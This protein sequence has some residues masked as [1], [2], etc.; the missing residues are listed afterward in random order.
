LPLYLEVFN[1]PLLMEVG[2]F[3][4]L[5]IPKIRGH[6]DLHIHRWDFCFIKKCNR[7]KIPLVLLV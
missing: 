4:Y 2:D 6:L 3:I 5:F 7:K 1:L